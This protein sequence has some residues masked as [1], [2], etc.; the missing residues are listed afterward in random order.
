MGRTRESRDDQLAVGVP[1]RADR[2]DRLDEPTYGFGPVDPV[3]LIALAF[4]RADAEDRAATRQQ[5]QRR[6]RLRGDRRIAATRVGDADSESQPADPVLR[7]HVSEHCPWLEACIGVR[8]QA[9]RAKVFRLFHDS[10]WQQRVQMVWH[11]QRIDLR[12]VGVQIPRPD[13][14]RRTEPAIDQNICGPT[15]NFAIVLS[16]HATRRL[17]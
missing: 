7:G 15:P 17:C 6:D 3:G 13:Q 2:R 11:P 1:Q 4:A 14:G 5:M 8:H 9:S 10:S 12:R 16:L